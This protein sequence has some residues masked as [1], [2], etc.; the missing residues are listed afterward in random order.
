MSTWN[1]KISM[2]PRHVEPRHFYGFSAN[3][4]FWSTSAKDILCW[5]LGLS[6]YQMTLHHMTV[7]RTTSHHIT[8]HHITTTT[9]PQRKFNH[10]QIRSNY[11]HK[12]ARLKAG[13]RK[14]LG[15]GSA[16][17]GAPAHIL[18]SIG[19]LFLWLFGS[20]P[21]NFRPRLVRALLV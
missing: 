12:T 3:V 16:R 18:D 20:S 9:D 14:K 17:V 11:R 21:R 10:H 19:K 15:L 13:A 6:G 7:H 5:V 2:I 8:V 4:L 1:H